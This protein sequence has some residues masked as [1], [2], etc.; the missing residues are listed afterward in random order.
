MK[1]MPMNRSGRSVAAARRVIEIDEVL[2]AIRSCFG[3]QQM[4]QSSSV[5]DLA[6]DPL[7]FGRR[8]DDQISSRQGREIRVLTRVIRFKGCLLVLIFP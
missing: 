7:V 6:L 8:L 4:G 3:L 2:E 1:C 5:I